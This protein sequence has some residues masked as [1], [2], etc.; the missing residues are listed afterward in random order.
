MEKEYNNTDRNTIFD[1]NFIEDVK[2]QLEHQKP[3]YY[4]EYLINEKSTTINIYSRETRVATLE[5]DIQKGSAVEHSEE[6][7]EDYFI[8]VKIKPTFPG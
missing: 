1:V 5:L 6:K 3:Q 4:Y 2:F 8:R 7:L